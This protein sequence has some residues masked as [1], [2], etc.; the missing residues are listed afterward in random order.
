MFVLN[1]LRPPVIIQMQ[2]TEMEMATL[3]SSAIVNLPQMPSEILLVF[4]QGLKG[5]F[6]L[7]NM[8]PTF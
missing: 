3:S 5:R 4:R 2:T 7:N 1:G 6:K 8:K